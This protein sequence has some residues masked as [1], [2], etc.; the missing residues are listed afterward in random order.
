MVKIRLVR[1]GAKK[2]PFYKIVIADSRYPRNGKFIE[3]IGFFKPLLSIKHPP[4]ICI[5]TLRIT[6]WIKNGAI[7]SKRVKKLVKI[8]SYINKKIK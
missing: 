6:H 8:H 4:Q 3:K 5:N 7:M 2:R 1:L